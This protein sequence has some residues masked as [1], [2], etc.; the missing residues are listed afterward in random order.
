M[1]INQSGFVFSER[2]SSTSFVIFAKTPI[3]T[4]IVFIAG[5]TQTLN[6]DGRG[7]KRKFLFD[8][9]SLLE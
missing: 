3:A 1:P 5:N 6:Q 8:L 2:P 9:T 7:E 4:H